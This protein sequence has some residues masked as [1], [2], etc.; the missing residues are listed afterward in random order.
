MACEGKNRRVTR[1]TATGTVEIIA[2]EWQGARLNAP[3]DAIVRADG[4]IFFTDPDY[5]I[6][7]SRELSFNGVYR[8]APDRT[9]TLVA[10]DLDKPNGVALSPDGATLYVSDEAAGFL[11]AYDVAADGSTS[12]PRK[13]AEASHPDGVAV[14][15]AGNV[16]VAALGGIAVFAP[17][18]SSWGTVDVPKQP[19]NLAFGGANRKTLFITALDT[20]YSLELEVA[21]PP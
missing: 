16:F 5:S 20:L 4:T 17:D 19:A 21:G 1:T 6:Q 8:V 2:S 10:D 11:R 14:D 12:N 3:N 9:M 7:G 13:W 15:D 18:G